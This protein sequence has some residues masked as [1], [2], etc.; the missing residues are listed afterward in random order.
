[1]HTCC[2]TP[3]PWWGHRGRPI[4]YPTRKTQYAPTLRRSHVK[5]VVSTSWLLRVCMKS[6]LRCL[7]CDLSPC[8]LF[9]HT[10][11]CWENKS[12]SRHRIKAS[13]PSLQCLWL[14]KRSIRAMKCCLS[15]INELNLKVPIHYLSSSLASLHQWNKNLSDNDNYKTVAGEK[16]CPTH[17]GCYD[18]RRWLHCGPGARVLL[19]HHLMLLETIFHT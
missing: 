2:R 12:Q 13:L 10:S 8:T 3:W 17:A 14:F 7:R 18:G 1:M 9:S 19:N 16:N 4:P 6:W 5:R 11:V 15:Q